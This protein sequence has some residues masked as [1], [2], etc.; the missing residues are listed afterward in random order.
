MN[1]R[2][3]LRCFCAGALLAALGCE[4]LSPLD[5][6]P[7]Q[8]DAAVDSSEAEACR[9]CFTGDAGACRSAYDICSAD[10]A[11]KSVIDCIL[12]VDCLRQLDFTQTSANLPECATT[13]LEQA[14]TT[15]NAIVTPAAQFF[16]C[17]T[18]AKKCRSVCFD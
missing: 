9:E 4:D 11:C 5:Y 6:Q 12:A 1:V 7:P 18:D 8:R 13:C 14:D 16:G 10:V 2:S 15:I 17:A 3:L